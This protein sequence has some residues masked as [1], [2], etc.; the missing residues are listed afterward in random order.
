MRFGLDCGHSYEGRYEDRYKLL[1]FSEIS[2]SKND[3]IQNR[4]FTRQAQLSVPFAVTPQ[5]AGAVTFSMRT[6]K[7][8]NSI[9]EES[10]I[11]LLRSI[12]VPV[13]IYCERRG[14]H[15][16][17]EGADVVE[18]IAGQLL[19]ETGYLG[20]AEIVGPQA[21]DRIYKW[22]NTMFITPSRL[23]I[24][25]RVLLRQSARI[26]SRLVDGT[27][28][29]SNETGGKPIYWPLANVLNGGDIVALKSPTSHDHTSWHRLASRHPLLILAV[30]EIN[31]RLLSESDCDIT[32]NPHQP[33]NKFGRI[34]RISHSVSAH[35]AIIGSPY[36]I[37]RWLH[38][39]QGV[40]NGTLVVT[41]DE[42]SCGTESEK[43]LEFSGI[44]DFSTK[45][46][47]NYTSRLPFCNPSCRLDQMSPLYSVDSSGPIIP[48]KV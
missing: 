36:L 12:S 37:N 20:I 3:N 10:Q 46:H 35:G 23:S 6:F 30:G 48:R 40:W 2:E 5:I 29:A 41:E 13:L 24:S 1:A 22:S 17:M 19:R 8:S 38:N 43:T 44:P 42:T 28:T 45:N 14:L 7:V 47:M 16:L 32:W 31:N 11:M 15:L 21:G 26:V 27:K 25:G 34:R 18:E 4:V 9:D 39:A 33:I